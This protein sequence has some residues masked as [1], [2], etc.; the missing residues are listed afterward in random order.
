ME[1]FL[2]FYFNSVFVFNS[3]LEDN[4]SL[5]GAEMICGPWCDCRGVCVCWDV[6]HIQFVSVGLDPIQGFSVHY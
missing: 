3:A 6:D 5:M 4:R 1:L 2:G